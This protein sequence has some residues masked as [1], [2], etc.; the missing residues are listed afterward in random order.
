MATP[1]IGELLIAE[2]VLTEA[3][4][5]R[6]LGFQRSSLEKVKIGSI[7]LNW[8]LLSE[9]ALLAGLAKLHRCPGVPWA[10]LLDASAKLVRLLSASHAA[11]LGA[12]PYADDRRL[13][14]VA[15]VNPSNIAA[16]DEV[17]ALTGRS[18]APGVA[19]EA[20]L[21][22]AHQKF[23]GR[24]VPMEYRTILQKL[25]RRTTTALPGAR[26]GAAASGVSAASQPTPATQASPANPAP[27]VR[28]PVD[29][30]PPAVAS[31]S[32]ARL[33]ASPLPPAL[34]PARGER[35]D[36]LLA[37]PLETLRPSLPEAAA[38]RKAREGDPTPREGGGTPPRSPFSGDDSLSDWV[39]QAISA[40]TE[41]PRSDVDP[42]S[43]AGVSNP[44][45]FGR[46]SSDPDPEPIEF[47]VE[48]LPPTNAF[49]GR[50]RR[51]E[52]EAAL[53][54][55]HT[56]DVPSSIPPFRRATDPTVSFPRY[57]EPSPEFEPEEEA[58]AGM[59][60]PAPP[61]EP[62]DAAAVA[63]SRE[64]LAD[65]ILEGPLLPLPRVMLLGAG[66]SGV[67]G[68]RGRGERLSA[69]VVSS[70][71]IPSSE[72]SIFSAV[73]ESGVPHFG[74][75]DRSEWPRAFEELFGR[76]PPDCAIFPIRVLDSVAAFLYADRAGAPMHY[77][78]FAMVARATASAA[79][80]LSRFV[81]QPERRSSLSS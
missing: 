49:R 12:L 71:R 29:G 50:P 44:A 36:T 70:I 80:V 68:W 5:Q 26:P 76:V 60:R 79:S 30:A 54:E 81:L 13:L 19:T 3:S 35:E 66:T 16:I 8:E 9:E 62:A 69:E 77:E 40:F 6:A 58:V 15:F 74:A 59:W 73:H 48:D 61:E 52:S 64:E 31:G 41:V 27:S 78:D 72:L 63:R 32:A 43:P 75:I 7:L 33:E 20:R 10:A 2:G 28:I 22:Q 38:A 1:R 34:S 25:D 47:R 4:I 17:S 18:V 67:T 53:S 23:Y 45:I 42:G 65:Y 24:H 37:A 51:V 55:A 39:G 56:R 57:R 11:R 21:L 46:D 14:R